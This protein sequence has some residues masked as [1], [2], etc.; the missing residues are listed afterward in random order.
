M[1]GTT[2]GDWIWADFSYIGGKSRR[3]GR[4]AVF[5]LHDFVREFAIEQF[6]VIASFGEW[7]NL[8]IEILYRL[9]AGRDED[10]I[11]AE[12]ADFKEDWIA[13]H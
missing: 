6:E 2:L 10:Q 12:W 9:P 3:S 11:E 5:L 4:L 8:R 13:K 1:N 7:Q